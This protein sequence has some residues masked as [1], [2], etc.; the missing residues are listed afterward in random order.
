MRLIHAY[1]HILDNSGYTN[2]ITHAITRLHI[3]DRSC[4][5]WCETLDGEPAESLRTPG[6]CRRNRLVANGF[7][8][9]FKNTIYVK[10]A[11]KS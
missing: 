4:A 5:C 8:A 11:K 7:V 6:R 3:D 1:L 2:V 10:I 9:T